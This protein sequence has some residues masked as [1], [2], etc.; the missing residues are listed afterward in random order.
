ME[1]QLLLK[2]IQFFFKKNKVM[3]VLSIFLLLFSSTVLAQDVDIVVPSSGLKL[4]KTIKINSPRMETPTSVDPNSLYS[5]VTNYSGF[6]Y[7]NGGAVLQSGNTIT[8]MVADSL[9]LVGTPPFSVG[10]FT[11]SVSNSNKVDVSARPRIRFYAANGTDGSPGTLITGFTFAAISF[12]AAAIQLF[13][14][15]VTPFTVPT[16][17]IWA[18]ITFDNNAGATGATLAQL[19]SLGQ[20]IFDVVD[21]GSSSAD[22]F[23]TDA[24]GDFLADNPAGALYDFGPPPSP[25]ANFGW[26][27]VS[28][29]TLPVTLNNFKVQSSGEINTLSWTTSQEFNSNYFEIE[30][31]NNG[32]NFDPI[33][34]VKAAGKSNVPLNY[35]FTDVNPEANINYYRLRFVDINN[36]GSYSEIKSVKNSGLVKFSVYPN[37]ATNS[38]L[39]KV[40]GDK[41]ENAEVSITDINGRK[42]LSR[43]VNIIQGYNNFPVDVSRLAQG[44][45]YM[46]IQLSN[47]S[48]VKKFTKL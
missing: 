4:L 45:Y 2:K 9:A 8:T 14:G 38:I 30:R 3:Y 36:S 23:Q 22:Y 32:I 40:N 48:F 41:T 31:G 17:A 12:K 35:Q 37:P 27:L 20:G 21:K 39:L 29:G 18:G 26:E 7:S 47:D 1:K 11:F 19:D 6:T 5:D 25:I 13:G 16:Q 42:V 24:A 15:N 44:S 33:G 10:S 28:S 46:K 34:Q 43:Q